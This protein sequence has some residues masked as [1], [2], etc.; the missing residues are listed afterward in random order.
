MIYNT[1]WMTTEEKA[2]FD[3]LTPDRQKQVVTH[4]MEL[5]HGDGAA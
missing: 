2:L 4:S 5:L 3:Q 1:D